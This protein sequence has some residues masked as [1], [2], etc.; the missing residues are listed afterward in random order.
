MKPS[1]SDVILLKPNV[2]LFKIMLSFPV[3]QKIKLYSVINPFLLLKIS[4]HALKMHAEWKLSRERQFAKDILCQV[5]D[6]DLIGND[7]VNCLEICWKKKAFRQVSHRPCHINTNA[8]RRCQI[9]N[10][11]R[12]LA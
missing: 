4:V 8:R 12:P 3:Y 9:F 6:V 2:Q 10:G 7:L 5:S 11:W 1:I